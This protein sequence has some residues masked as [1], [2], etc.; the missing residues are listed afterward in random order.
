MQSS[1]LSFLLY[2][3]PALFLCYFLIPARFRGARNFVL[4]AISLFF[5]RCG[6]AR[7][8]LLLSVSIAVN[9]CGGLLA[10]PGH[11]P[12]VRRTGLWGAVVVGLGLSYMRLVAGSFN[13]FICFQ[14]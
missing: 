10:A 5:Y 1:S 12:R 6:G 8:L 14:F 2:F 13:P 3:L 4:L 11:L 9:Y 7:H